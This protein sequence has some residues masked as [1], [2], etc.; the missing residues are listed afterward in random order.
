MCKELGL[1]C[2]LLSLGAFISCFVVLHMLNKIIHIHLDTAMHVSIPL[3]A[4]DVE[5]FG[6]GC[7]NTLIVNNLDAPHLSWLELFYMRWTVVF[8][9]VYSFAATLLNRAKYL[10][11][12]QINLATSN[13]MILMGSLL[14]VVLLLATVDLHHR[15]HFMKLWCNDFII[16]HLYYIAITTAVS[17]VFFITHSCQKHL[18][19]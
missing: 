10:G 12:F 8:T 16:Y 7:Q 9:L 13:A 17:V 2:G 15:E 14:S 4:N 6:S 1:C 5:V 11:D 18:S 19:E 3:E